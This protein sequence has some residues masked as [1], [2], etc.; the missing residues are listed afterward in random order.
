MCISLSW[1]GQAVL[2]TVPVEESL[3]RFHQR[4]RVTHSCRRRLLLV[5]V[6]LLASCRAQEVPMGR[7][8]P[9]RIVVA[10]L[11]PGSRSVKVEVL[12]LLLH[13]HLGL[14]VLSQHWKVPLVAVHP[15]RK[16]EIDVSYAE[17]ATILTLICTSC[18][19]SPGTQPPGRGPPRISTSRSRGH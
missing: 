1:N 11:N 19:G 14:L 5:E 13:R 17:R 18:P 2:V 4:R 9:R 12:L 10:G 6:Q 15:I 16:K 3:A 8:P 7:W